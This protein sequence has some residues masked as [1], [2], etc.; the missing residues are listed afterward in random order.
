M[1]VHLIAIL[2]T[3]PSISLNARH[4]Q[5][6]YIDN[7]SEMCTWKWNK[8]TSPSFCT[9][10]KSEVAIKMHPTAYPPFK[11]LDRFLPLITCQ[12]PVSSYNINTS[13]HQGCQLIIKFGTIPLGIVKWNRD[14]LLLIVLNK[15]YNEITLFHICF[16]CK[17]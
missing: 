1:W 16:N 15:I 9:L 11:I 6:Y 10:G 2:C 17:V 14:P 3:S 8:R 12:K 4:V 7:E 5:S 13:L